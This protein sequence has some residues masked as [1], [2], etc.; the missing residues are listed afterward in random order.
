MPS[1]RSR[2]K[3]TCRKPLGI[4]LVLLLQVV[5]ESPAQSWLSWPP[6]P[7]GVTR[8]PTVAAPPPLRLHIESLHSG[9]RAVWLD[10]QLHGPVEVRIESTRPIA[11]M[12]VQQVLTRHGRN[13]VAI[14]SGQPALDLRFVAVPGMP[15]IT[16]QS[17]IYQFPL[18]GVPV[19]VGQGP[20]GRFSHQDAENRHAIDFSAPIGTPVIAARAGT[21][22]Q[23][24]DRFRDGSGRQEETNFIRVLHTDGS[25]AV[26]AHLHQ[27]S[28]RVKPGQRVALGEQLAES[29]NSGYS[30]AP[31][32]HFVL[33]ANTGMQLVSLPFRM[34]S[35]EG[36]LSLPRE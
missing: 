3:N 20:L 13:Q 33:Q 29:G 17:V 7:G 16:A 23:A 32:L 8:A 22:M 28:A 15:G 24:E 6:K 14:L 27:H 30:T 19:R 31:H 5:H 25:M 4:F 21:V 1:C 35:A 26:Y 34:R 12:P 18:L 36:E 9:E 11:G 2:P 10:N